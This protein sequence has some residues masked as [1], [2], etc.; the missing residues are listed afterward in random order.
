MEW[1]YSCEFERE[2]KTFPQEKIPD[3]MKMF[4]LGKILVMGLENRVLKF[5]P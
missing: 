2:G 4:I 1:L 5:Y 3:R